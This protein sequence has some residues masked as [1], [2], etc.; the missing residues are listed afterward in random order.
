MK[1]EITARAEKSLRKLPLFIQKKAKKQFH[2]LL[3]DHRHPSLWVKR[4]GGSDSFEGRIDIH[5]RFTFIV[6]ADSVYIMTVGMHDS[7]LGKK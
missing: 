7:G 4:M 1:L 3:L 5:Y 6:E 2:I